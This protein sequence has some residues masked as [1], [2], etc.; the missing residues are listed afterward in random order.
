VLLTRIA[1]AAVLGPA[2]IAGILFLPPIYI[3]CALLVFLA[4]AAW[5]WAGLAD[6]SRL[7]RL[8]YALAT[9][10]AAAVVVYGAR[11]SEAVMAGM[12]L[13]A[14]AGWVVALGL[15]A[16]PGRD[17]ILSAV[18]TLPVLMTGWAIL[19][20]AWAVIVLLLQRDTTMLIGLFLIVWAADGGAYIIG[21]KWGKRRLAPQISPGKTWEGVVGGILAGAATAFIFSDHVVFSANAALAYRWLA[22]GVV[23]FSVIGDLFESVMKRHRHVKDSGSLIPG[24]GGVL[25]RIDALLAAAPVYAAG[26]VYW[27]D[28]L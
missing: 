3:G 24:H 25:D 23:A 19:L 18:G 12:Y 11:R 28:R 15:I 1:T 16:Y 22:V 17:R 7:W 6:S 20:P 26:L 27:V 2:L 14:V 8:C 13:V 10:V 4:A 21:K 9:V 5:E